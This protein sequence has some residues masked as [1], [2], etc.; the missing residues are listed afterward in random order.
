MATLVP[1]V[2][3]R[4]VPPLEPP[5]ALAVVEVEVVV[6]MVVAGEDTLEVGVDTHT[7]THMPRHLPLHLEVAV[8]VVVVVLLPVQVAG[9]DGVRRHVVAEHNRLHAESARHTR[10]H[11]HVTTRCVH[12]TAA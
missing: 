8:V 12:R 11:V 3:V 9:V 4:Q 2:A 5:L 6:H 1:V 7:H 10:E